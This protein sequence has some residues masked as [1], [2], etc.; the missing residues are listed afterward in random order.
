M[1][2]LLILHVGSAPLKFKYDTFIFLFS[3]EIRLLK[4]II[5]LHFLNFFFLCF[6]TYIVFNCERGLNRIRIAYRYTYI[7]NEGSDKNVYYV[8]KQ[9]AGTVRNS[10]ICIYGFSDLN[11][12]FGTIIALRRLNT[13]LCPILNCDARS[14]L[15]VITCCVLCI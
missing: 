15:K 9:P 2:L 4:T 14:N 6:Y 11:H 12:K 3:I 10:S 7:F 1:Y 5:E 13:M 8:P